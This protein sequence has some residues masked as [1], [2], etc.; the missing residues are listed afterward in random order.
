MVTV[1]V[2]SCAQGGLW[3]WLGNWGLK[4]EEQ[5]PLCKNKVLH[6]LNLHEMCF[7]LENVT[8]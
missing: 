3:A 8:P 7:Y 1:L 2:I 4:N 5:K 6:V